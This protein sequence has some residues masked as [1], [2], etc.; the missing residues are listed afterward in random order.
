MSKSPQSYD[1]D[2]VGRVFILTC[3]ADVVRWDS[4]GVQSMAAR[5]WNVRGLP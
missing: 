5:T 1:W 2:C 3:R 4:S